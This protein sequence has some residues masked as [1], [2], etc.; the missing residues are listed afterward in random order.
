MLFCVLPL[1]NGIFATQTISLLIYSTH[2]KK[3]YIQLRHFYT[4]DLSAFNF[5]A[6]LTP[7][8]R[9][10]LTPSM[11]QLLILTTYKFFPWARSLPWF[12]KSWKAELN[13][14][15]TVSQWSKCFFLTHIAVI[16]S[17]AQKT[18]FKILVHWYHVPHF[19]TSGILRALV[20]AGT[21]IARRAQWYI[22]GEV[23]LYWGSFG[24]RSIK[25]IRLIFQILQRLQKS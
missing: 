22:S 8:E 14:Q 12:C 13:K 7:F 21:V 15:F 3:N 10:C 5:H 19:F 2:K 23:V 4:S 18:R 17:K 20:F 24:I 9:M 11:L 16:A 25:L 1:H 6:S